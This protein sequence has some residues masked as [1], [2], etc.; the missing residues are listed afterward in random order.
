[1]RYL[2]DPHSF[3]WFITGDSRL[4]QTARVLIENRTH[5]IFVSVACL[6]EI[7]IKSSLG[8]LTLTQPYEILIPDQ[9]SRNEIALL[10]IT[11]N[12]LSCLSL[13]PYHHRD[14]FDRLI[15]AQSQM[16]ALP[17]ITRDTLFD[18]YDITVLW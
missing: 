5:S 14:P 1:M 8:K 17:V 6:W 10:P 7:A 13:L 18:Q 12:H 11:V 9:L 15:I 4:S 3:L 2:L 16:E